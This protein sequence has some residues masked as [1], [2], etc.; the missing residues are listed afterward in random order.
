MYQPILYAEDDENDAFFMARA[1]NEAGIANHLEIVHDGREAIR[2]LAGEGRFADR[3]TFPLPFLVLLDFKLPQVSGLEVLEWVR[4]Q[5]R[6]RQMHV[7]V[8]AG[9][10]EDRNIPE[11]LK[12]G[13]NTYLMKPPTAAALL[14][15]TRVLG[16][17]GFARREATSHSR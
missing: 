1:L 16:P 2:Y 9:L 10:R 14:T 13:A 8:L 15:M 7:V 4:G 17:Q 12:L 3:A 6:F 11:A 5:S